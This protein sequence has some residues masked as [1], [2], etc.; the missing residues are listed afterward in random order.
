MQFLAE[1]MA[2]AEPSD[3]ELAAYLHLI[4]IGSDR[5]SVTFRQVF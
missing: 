1:D 4:R 5:G 2:A 3:E